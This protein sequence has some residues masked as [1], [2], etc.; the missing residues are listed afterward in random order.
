MGYTTNFQGEFGLNKELT[1]TLKTFLEKLA[2]TRRMSRVVDVDFGVEGEFYVE[3]DE[4]GVTD[5]NNPSRTQPG[6]WCQWIPTEDGMGI[7]WDCN[8]KFYNYSEWLVYI[9]DTILA[10]NGYVLNGTVEYRGE[11]FSDIGEL[12]V[13]DNQVYFRPH[14]GADIMY[15]KDLNPK[16]VWM[17]KVETTVD[18]ADVDESEDVQFLRTLVVELEN[19]MGDEAIQLIEDKIEEK[20]AQSK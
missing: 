13:E 20:L 3:N 7:E 16:S 1:P 11:E 14:K 6:L 12:V 2:D 9:I 15:D 18:E 10:P 17:D 19:G 8:E 4:L 5:N